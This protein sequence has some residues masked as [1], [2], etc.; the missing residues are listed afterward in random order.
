MIEKNNIKKGGRIAG[1]PNKVTAETR[2]QFRNLLECNFDNIQQDLD[3]LK[4]M[5]R[6]TVLIQIAKIVLPALKSIQ[7]EDKTKH[8]GFQPI[9]F[10]FS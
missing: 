8:N 2:A 9:V 4:P 3:S 1:T 10:E 5:E 6:L 7:Y